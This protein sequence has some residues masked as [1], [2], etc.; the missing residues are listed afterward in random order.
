MKV[1]RTGGAALVA[2]LPRM[3]NRFGAVVARWP[4]RACDAWRVID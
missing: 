4:T 1:R 3:A 2:A